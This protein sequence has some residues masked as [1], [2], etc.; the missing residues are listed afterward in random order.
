MG[1]TEYFGY[2]FQ[3]I[4][5]SGNNRG[6]N[7]ICDVDHYCSHID[8]TRN[9]RG[10]GNIEMREINT[11]NVVITVYHG[12]IGRG[13]SIIEIPGEYHISPCWFGV[14]KIPIQMEILSFGD[15]QR[16]RPIIFIDV[17]KCTRD[18]WHLG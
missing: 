6:W 14:G 13:I 3:W 7:R 10:Q 11:V 16:R 1:G 5:T 2:P 17:L 12:A 8:I 9:I 4:S 15:A 18:S